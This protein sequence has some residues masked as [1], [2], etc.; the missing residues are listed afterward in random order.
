MLRALDISAVRALAG[1][2]L[3][4]KHDEQIARGGVRRRVGWRS[5]RPHQE[6]EAGAGLLLCADDG[7][8]SK[9]G[10]ATIIRTGVLILSPRASLCP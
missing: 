3:S 4:T 9:P 6:A 2:T 8:A 10:S 7:A 5:S 1:E